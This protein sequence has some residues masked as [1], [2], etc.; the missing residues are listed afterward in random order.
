MTA[1]D[2][3]ITDTFGG[4]ANY[5]WVSREKI[6]IPDTYTEPWIVRMLKAHA[7]WTGDR[8]EVMNLGTY[9]EI[10]PHGVCQVLF[11]TPNY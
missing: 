1:W 11:A 8:C 3:E 7:G 9:I 2:I 5:S 6:E 10:R 4:E